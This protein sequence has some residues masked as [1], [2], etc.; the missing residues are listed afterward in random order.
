MKSIVR[1]SD[2]PSPIFENINAFNEGSSYMSDNNNADLTIDNI[3]RKNFAGVTP[4]VIKLEATKN[5]NL[6]KQSLIVP[7]YPMS[8]SFDT[9]VNQDK[10]QSYLGFSDSPSTSVN[11]SI[12]NNC[13]HTDLSEL[14][15]RLANNLMWNSVD[16]LKQD[17][18]KLT[19]TAA[20]KIIEPFPDFSV[21]HVIQHHDE[22][23]DPNV[24]KPTSSSIKPK[25]SSIVAVSS[26]DKSIAIFSSNKTN[27]SGLTSPL[28][29]PLKSP[30]RKVSSI[31]LT[32]KNPVKIYDDSLT[33]TVRTNQSANGTTDITTTDTNYTPKVSEKDISPIASEVN[34]RHSL[35]PC[36]E[37]PIVNTPVAHNESM[38]FHSSPAIPPF[39]V[40]ESSKSN[41][42]S[43][44]DI[45]IEDSLNLSSKCKV[46]SSIM[47][48][49]EIKSI[50]QNHS[51]PVNTEIFSRGNSYNTTATTIIVP[52]P[53]ITMNSSIEKVKWTTDSS[54]VAPV[55]YSDVYSQEL[56]GIAAI[57]DSKNTTTT[58]IQ[59]ITSSVTKLG[60]QGGVAL[61]K[62]P[63][64]MVNNKHCYANAIDMNHYNNAD[65][66]NSFDSSMKTSHSLKQAKRVLVSRV[67]NSPGSIIAKIPERSE[68]T[69]V[70]RKK[71]AFAVKS[72]ITPKKSHIA[73]ST[74]T[75][76]AQSQSKRDIQLASRSISKESHRQDMKALGINKVEVA[77]IVSNSCCGS[78]TSSI[79][80]CLTS[81]DVPNRS[82]KHNV[83][84]Q[85]DSFL[86]SESTKQHT[87]VKPQSLKINSVATATNTS[88][89]DISYD[90]SAIS[91]DLSQ[92]VTPQMNNGAY[93]HHTPMFH[94]YYKNHHDSDSEDNIEHGLEEYLSTASSIAALHSFDDTASA[95]K[96]F[97][98][99]NNNIVMKQRVQTQPWNHSFC[100]ENKPWKDT[101]VN[102]S[103]SNSFR[104]SATQNIQ[105][106]SKNSSF[107]RTS[108]S[109][110]LGSAQRVCTLN[111]AT[112]SPL[113]SSTRLQSNHKV[114]DSY[115]SS[116]RYNNT[117]LQKNHHIVGYQEVDYQNTTILT[118]EAIAA[119]GLVPNDD[120]CS[121]QLMSQ[122]FHNEVLDYSMNSVDITKAE[123]TL[124][125]DHRHPLDVSLSPEALALHAKKGME[126][127]PRLAILPLKREKGAIE[128]I[129]EINFRSFP[130]EQTTIALTISNHRNKTIRMNA[131]TVSLR[132]EEISS[133]SSTRS[134]DT[135]S[136]I[137]SGTNE[138]G[139][140]NDDEGKD[141][142]TVETT[143]PASSFEVYPAEINILPGTE[144]LLYV[145]FNPMKLL[146][147]VYSGAIKIRSHRKVCYC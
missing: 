35:L 94:S 9:S 69:K 93:K 86:L 12:P 30:R 147:G 25:T 3:D 56:N 97:D 65:T 73:S 57:I 137:Y 20:S 10:L 99:I 134:I 96:G 68:A 13:I 44:N 140:G 131:H 78:S 43:N 24:L 42:T 135:R 66:E 58:T 90:Y 145:T 123:T 11:I 60:R 98:H 18:E 129:K 63:R 146:S 7:E 141:S 5:M 120:Y 71:L 109:S 125:L 79:E 14:Q 84:I 75:L 112:K 118:D 19:P 113:A 41:S 132:F 70:D 82:E 23:C 64:I 52:Q 32:P 38:S 16:N 101:A 121:H 28:K 51:Q 74:A 130:G 39:S 55:S 22:N 119:T 81:E 139:S 48:Q 133:S 15:S 116:S 77:S 62:G 1:F 100:E 53:S 36:S 59:T 108:S 31:A 104:S 88:N 143:A 114:L 102:K 142:I 122:G 72:K 54:Y 103:K 124:T 85:C 76:L 80:S 37:S 89:A 106:L 117:L 50:E 136:S 45:V 8:Q 27:R 105:S 83:S 4:H 115:T 17:N 111:N 127:G 128:D 95:L 29:S 33:A 138:D 67:Q 49:T 92:K 47:F 107:A 144:G 87:N 6:F 40:S 126:C 46:S 110:V 26:S 61:G 34:T 21:K 91:S 2:K